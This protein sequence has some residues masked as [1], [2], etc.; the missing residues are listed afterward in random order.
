LTDFLCSLLESGPKFA[1]GSYN[2]GVGQRLIGDIKKG[3]TGAAAGEFNANYVTKN[4]NGTPTKVFVKGLYN[5]NTAEENMF[6]NN[7][8]GGKP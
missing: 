7:D 6:V 2:G 4:V 3:D 1:R 5:R 8:Y